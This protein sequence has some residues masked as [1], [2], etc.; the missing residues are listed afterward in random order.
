MQ[1]LEQ[2]GGPLA[3]RM[4]LLAMRVFYGGKSLQ[5]MIHRSAPLSASLPLEPSQTSQMYAL[6]DSH[7]VVLHDTACT[8]PLHSSDQYFS[9]TAWL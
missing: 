7:L 8:Q 6:N 5:Q 9:A 2:A 1:L 3:M 4:L